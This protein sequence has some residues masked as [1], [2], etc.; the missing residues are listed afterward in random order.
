MKI[1]ILKEIKSSENRVILIP[2]DV[3]KLIELDH[4]V[5]VENGAGLYS[6]F[7]DT[8]YEAVGAHILPTSEKIFS[9]VEMIL[10]VQPPM[11]IEQELFA[12]HH[13]SISYLFLANNPDLL[14]S[15]LKFDSI[16]FSAELFS[17][18]NDSR[19]VLKSMSHLAGKIAIFE[20]ARYLQKNQGGKGI[21]LGY[22]EG[23]RSSN[24]TI[25]G[26]GSG[27]LAAAEQ[28]LALG[29]DVNLI[30]C[31]PDKLEQIIN[32]NPLAE[33]ITFEFSRGLLREVLLNTDVLITAV[34]TPG[35]KVPVLV[36][37]AD[38]KLMK[39]GS[40]IID[41]SIDQ[42]GCVETSRPTTQ[43]NPV[44]IHDEIVHY[45]VPNIPSST[46]TT[47]SQ[48]MSKAIMPYICQIAQL[49]CEEVI[50]LHP[51][52]RNGLTLYHGNVVNEDLAGSNRLEYFDVRE[53]LELSL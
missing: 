1:G 49:G 30:D 45:C 38:V 37:T 40:V 46:P 27:G 17:N 32:P 22:N 53:M 9:T 16:F 8:E 36:E 48:L 44:F 14:N 24:V 43:E 19:P 39:P 47:S 28:A 18:S 25:I 21:L 10:K 11:P 12:E 31:N 52:V 33:L 6:S 20:A 34:Q 3:E 5:Y 23:A 42:G 51:E 2:R 41:L 4:D 15:L 50:A 13:L 7:P 26:A 29:A 35:K